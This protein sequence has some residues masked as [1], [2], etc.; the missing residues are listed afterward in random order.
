MYRTPEPRHVLLAL[1]LALAV[2]MPVAAANASPP[3]QVEIPGWLERIEY[4]G[5]SSQ[6]TVYV[7][8]PAA[9]SGGSAF[10]WGSAA[11]GG[12]FVAGIGL[13]AAGAALALRRRHRLAHA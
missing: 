3:K 9:A 1:V 8:T 4:P 12:G 6:P 7:T 5:T 2:A 10:D 13:I 11:V